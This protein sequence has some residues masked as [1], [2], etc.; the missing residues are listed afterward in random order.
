MH[1]QIEVW[2]S[3]T[4]AE[5]AEQGALSRAAAPVLL[6]PGFWSLAEL[7]RA[8]MPALLPGMRLPTV[9]QE[10]VLVLQAVLQV[11]PEAVAGSERQA[12]LGAALQR[13][14]CQLGAADVDA[15]CL[16]A[17]TAA[18]PSAARRAAAPLL[19]AL[20]WLEVQ[21]QARAWLLRHSLWTALRQ[22]L[23][24]GAP[25]P[26]VLQ[27]VP[28]LRLHADAQV[29]PA[30]WQLWMVLA[31]QRRS[32]GGRRTEVWLPWADI[33]WD[34]ATGAPGLMQHS[35]HW[36]RTFEAR[37]AELALEVVPDM[38]AAGPLFGAP[39]ASG[40]RGASP[41]ASRS[42]AADAVAAA[43]AAGGALE[44]SPAALHT[45]ASLV[46][47]GPS[48]SQVACDG[49]GAQVQAAAWLVD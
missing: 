22:A 16:R 35:V 39:L 12:R 29:S 23:A 8:L 10:R 11:W 13:S 25:P 31:Q 43:S 37:G 42:T 48:L 2:V 32:W 4:A 15:A 20:Q 27:Q 6:A 44:L 49:L 47:P 14:L 30:L 28:L 17:W 40:S 7:A 36:L 5:Q 45:A 18:L 3:P 1:A 46:A 34:A 19:A 9:V 33:P 26:E 38:Q 24:S 41:A 21:S